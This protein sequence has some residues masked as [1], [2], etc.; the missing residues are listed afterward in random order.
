M[1][2]DTV[3]D[4]VSTKWLAYKVDTYVK[5]DGRERTVGE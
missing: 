5:M 3:G 4:P 1:G 2:F